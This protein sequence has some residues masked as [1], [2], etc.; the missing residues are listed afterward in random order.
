MNGEI[1]EEYRSRAGIA[2][3]FDQFVASYTDYRVLTSSSPISFSQAPGIAD[4]ASSDNAVV[5]VIAL[6]HNK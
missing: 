1:S 6:L 5:H 4:C 3:P 2:E